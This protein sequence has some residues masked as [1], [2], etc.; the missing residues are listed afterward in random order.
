MY[1]ALEVRKVVVLNSIS[2]WYL[3]LHSV[4]NFPT[5]HKKK[6][7]KRNSS[8]G[9]GSGLKGNEDEKQ[10]KIAFLSHSRQVKYIIRHTS[11][12]ARDN[13]IALLLLIMLNGTLD[14]FFRIPLFLSLYH[15]R[16][17]FRKKDYW[18]KARSKKRWRFFFFS[19]FL[20]C[21]L[22]LQLQCYSMR[23]AF[24]IHM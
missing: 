17:R 6:A 19:F 1:G 10:G 8:G 14:K 12:S 22:H 21:H 16:I 23:K 2:F 5:D 11:C 3:P 7:L 20:L 13:H 24:A 9:G 18:R 4:S 15:I